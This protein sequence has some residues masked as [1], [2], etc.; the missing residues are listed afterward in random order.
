MSYFFFF[1]L[2][3]SMEIYLDL[4]RSYF[5]SNQPLSKS[6]KTTGR[7]FQLPDV[8]CPSLSISHLSQGPE[9]GG[10]FGVM[11]RAGGGERE[12]GERPR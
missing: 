7:S 12:G 11:E 3:F 5:N 10:R 4:A 6:P 2:L 8:F 9:S 1:F